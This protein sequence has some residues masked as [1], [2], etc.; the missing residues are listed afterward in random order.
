[1]GVTVNGN[2]NNYNLDMALIHKPIKGVRLSRRQKLAT[3]SMA[4]VAA[5]VALLV[6]LPVVLV[7]LRAVTPQPTDNLTHLF[8]T[9]L[10]G[11]AWTTAILAG[12]VLCLSLVIGVG[13]AWLVAAYQFPGRSFLSV[14]LTLP[15]AVPGFVLAYAYTD[16]LPWLRSLW[17]AALVLS[18]GL[19]PYIYMFARASFRTRP[20]SLIE[21]ARSL[22]VTQWSAWWKVVLPVAWPSIAAGAALVLMETLADF[23]A[24]SHFAVDTIAAGVYRSW[25]GLGDQ[26]SAAR[27][28]VLLVMMSIVLLAVERHARRKSRYFTRSHRGTAP[29]NTGPRFAFFAFVACAL[30]PTLGFFLPMAALAGSWWSNLEAGQTLWSSIT[31]PRLWQWTAHSAFYGV[32]A[33]SIT[34]PLAV[35]VAYANRLKDSGKLRLLTMLAA[36]GYAFPGI[37]LSIGLL[38][39]AGWASR[40]G[41]TG[42]ALGG[43]FAL[44]LWAY[45]TRFFAVANQ[46]IEAALTRVS[47]NMDASARSLGQSPWGVLRLVHWPMIRPAIGTSFA[48]VCVDALKELPA[49]LI[50][51][52][53]NTDTLAVAAYQFASDERLSAA[54]LPSLMIVLLALLPTLKLAL[55][56]RKT[57]D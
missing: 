57:H 53:F 3:R 9:V 42:L 22:G 25:Q 32:L 23:G 5:L 51:R 55:D 20:A 39:L 16:W 28:A 8:A 17:G 11:Y 19:Y 30:P 54:A 43:S 31:N 21:A 56:E 34:V 7:L 41:I 6:A 48:L 40:H 47:P 33:A 1:M 12:S 26:A 45:V 37:V 49:T 15:L 14:A 29:M 18:L 2:E 24:V 52:P 27:L 44:L 4:L 46:G 38:V 35:L 50:L 10:P 36:S 13:C